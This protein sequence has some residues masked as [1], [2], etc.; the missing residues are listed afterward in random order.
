M[1]MERGTHVESAAGSVTLD[2]RGGRPLL[3]TPAEA[4][5]LLRLGRSTIFELMAA[6]DIPSVKVGRTR[7]IPLAGVERWIAQQL[8]E[9]ARDA[10]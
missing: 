1:E 6:G 2:R 10:A 3:V 7:R 4:A 8:A 9:G 5:A